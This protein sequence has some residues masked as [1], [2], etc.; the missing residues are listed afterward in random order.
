[1]HVNKKFQQTWGLN[2]FTEDELEQ[3]HLS[4]LEVLERTG[5]KVY[6]EEALELL[7]SAGATVKDNLVKIPA[8]M[9][10]DA[11]TTAP[12]KVSLYSRE[13]NMA[14]ALEKGNIYYGTGSDTPYTVD[15][16]TGE[17]RES[18]K[19]DV[20]NSALVADALENVDFIMSLALASD[21]PT[22][23][24]DLH[25]FEAMVTHTSKPICFTA[26][27]R[28]G[29]QD[30]I[31]MSRVVAGGE[32]ALQERPFIILYA[33][34]TSPLLHTR[35]AVEK[36]L[37][38][39]ENRIPVIYAPAVMSGATG[40]VTLAGSLVV[41]NAEILSGL[42]MHQLKS[43][44]APF[45]SGG[46][47]PPMNMNTSICSYGD[48]GRDLGCTS[49]VKLSQYYNL[50]VFTTAGCSDAQTFD[51][52]AGMEAGFNLLISG[53]AGGNLIH[54]LGYIGVGMTSSLEHLVLCN[55]AVGAVKYLIRGVDI[56]PE[57]LALDLI[58]K[59]GPG[60]NF[61]TQ[62]HTLQNFREQMFFTE[63][64]NRENYDNWKASG[65][66]NFDVRA[67]ER[68]RQ[69]LNE[70]QAKPLSHEAVQGLQNI[71]EKRDAALTSK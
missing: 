49:L 31:D 6:E 23:T 38:C 15:L 7:R 50:P 21:A 39:A 44:G 53:L 34:P 41:A 29:L 64:L 54:D 24:S 4:T 27:H 40:P 12:A 59:V 2:M 57:T 42:V 10:Q 62:K 13:G 20:K 56:N 25:H 51:Q 58:E 32:E 60:G 70:H 71:L 45:V 65:A 11:L 8:W 69:I 55:E 37:T 17:R 26:H 3:L 14:M 22:E 67:N 47:T 63:S 48:P 30:I 1:M 9:V 61:L 18:L 36:L 52:Q 68:V 28:H 33:E 35:E 5:V 66:K 16:E 19:Q 43:R 46:G